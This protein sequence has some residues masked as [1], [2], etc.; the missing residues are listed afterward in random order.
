LLDEAHVEGDGFHPRSV[1][2]ARSVIHLDGETIQSLQ[3][4]LQIV[5]NKI[6]QVDFKSLVCRSSFGFIDHRFGEG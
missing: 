4:I 2:R 3:Q 6:D 1:D 5:C